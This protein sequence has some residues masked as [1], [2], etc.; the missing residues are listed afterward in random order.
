MN[1]NDNDDWK[2]LEKW[3][4]TRREEEK[5][6]FGYIPEEFRKEKKIDS[7]VK[8]LNIT[9]GIF[10]IIKYIVI[11]VVV[12]IIAIILSV[13][14]S[15]IRSQITVDVVDTI[16]NKYK[17]KV[18]IKDKEIDKKEDGVYKLNVKN[19]EEITFTAIKDG[20]QLNEDLSDNTHKYYFNLWKDT[21]NKLKFKEIEKYNNE[22][23]EYHTYIEIKSEEELKQGVNIMNEFINFCGNENLYVTWDLYFKIGEYRIYPYEQMGLNEEKV[24][25][26]VLKKY[27]EYIKVN[28]KGNEF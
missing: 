19:N 20:N 14:I 2:E 9:G 17:V 6:R 24:K 7:L 28:N 12:A 23:L 15:N 18:G 4:F 21:S 22:L 8:A 13:N 11:F 10:K 25:N 3:N 26:N 1:N 27:E 5:E 16:E